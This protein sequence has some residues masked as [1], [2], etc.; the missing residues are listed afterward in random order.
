MEFQV[1]INVQ[2]REIAEGVHLHK[3]KKDLGAGDQ[4]LMFG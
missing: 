4:G 2:S 3:D 1:R